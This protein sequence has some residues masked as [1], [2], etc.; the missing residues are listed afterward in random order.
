[1]V[2]SCSQN[3]VILFLSRETLE[4][5]FSIMFNTVTG[6]CTGLKSSVQHKQFKVAVSVRWN[7]L[8]REGFIAG[9]L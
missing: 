5:H 3:N 9:L 4:T 8:K 2:M 6:Q 1:M 7:I